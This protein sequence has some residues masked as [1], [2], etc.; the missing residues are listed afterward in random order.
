MCYIGKRGL[1]GNMSFIFSWLIN[2]TL[3]FICN[4]TCFPSP[5]CIAMVTCSTHSVTFHKNYCKRYLKVK[6]VEKYVDY[7][8]DYFS[9]YIAYVVIF[10]S[11]FLQLLIY[12]IIVYLC[13]LF[14][15]LKTVI[16]LTVGLWNLSKQVDDNAEFEGL[17]FLGMNN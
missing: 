10:F 16:I 6:Q 17:F 14:A 1:F 15:N 8:R 3:P 5:T 11:L 13:R 4:K 9:V 7:Q 12:I 2:K